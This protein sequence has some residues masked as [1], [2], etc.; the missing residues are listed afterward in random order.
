MRPKHKCIA[1][2]ALGLILCSLSFY[3]GGKWALRD[4]ISYQPFGKRVIF[5]ADS[6]NDGLFLPE[7]RGALWNLRQ[8][9]TNE[10]TAWLE[11]LMDLSIR[12]AMLRR[13]VLPPEGREQMDRTLTRIADYRQEFPRHID[14][15]DEHP[16]VVKVKRKVDTFLKDY[17]RAD[18]NVE[19]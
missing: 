13:P 18:P 14:E 5:R 7:L 15:A 12:G 8:V 2:G 4:M 11:A 6:W 16:E 3:A 17:Q 9:G 19:P 10:A 1:V